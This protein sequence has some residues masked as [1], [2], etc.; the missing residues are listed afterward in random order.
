MGDQDRGFGDELSEMAMAYVISG[1]AK[2]LE[3]CK[4]MVEPM[5]K[6]EEWGDNLGLVVGHQLAGMSCMYDWLYDDLE[7]DLRERMKAKMHRQAEILYTYA[8]EERVWWH[9]M[10]LQNWCHVPTAGLTYAA[11]ALAGEDP[12]AE[13]WFR[14]ADHCF[15]N[16]HRALSRDG[17]SEEGQAY[18]TYAWEF[19]LRVDDI[20]KTVFGRDHFDNDN[21]RNASVR[22]D[23]LLA[24]RLHAQE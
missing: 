18:M 8:S 14:Q 23:V 10:Y 9:D 5:L 4:R 1:D 19:I 21:L 3:G 7:P 15:T 20:S 6:S 11:A 24:S 13:K 2:F 16:V 12:E 22:H 17:N